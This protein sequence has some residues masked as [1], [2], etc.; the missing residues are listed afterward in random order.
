VDGVV[1]SGLSSVDEAVITGE[2][3]PV[4]KGPGDVVT[5]GTTNQTG[6]LTVRVEALPADSAAAQLTALVS[7]AQS[8]GGRREQLLEAFAKWYLVLLVSAAALVATVPMAWCEW[9]GGDGGGDLV[10][11]A[12]HTHVGEPGACATWLH[13]AL[14]MVVVACPCALVV[15]MPIT[16]ACGVSSLARWG[17]LVKSSRQLELLAAVR[18][19]AMDKT[20][21]LTEGRFR[22]HR[23]VEWSE[24]VWRED[25][26]PTA[27]LHGCM[28]VDR[29]SARRPARRSGW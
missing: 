3:A 1:L 10:G 29:W 22:F 2:A 18:T 24:A 8:A 12:N 5:A 27:S 14:A 4:R 21:T 26:L 11:T 20:G 9:S 13:R 23:M 28:S 25:K 6:V 16:Y 19:L 17:V 15:A 7:D